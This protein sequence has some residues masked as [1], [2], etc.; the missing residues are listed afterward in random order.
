MSTE[1]NLEAVRQVIEQAFNQGNYAVLRTHFRPDFAEHQFGLHATIEGMQEDIQ[2]LRR[3]FPDLHLT[4]EDMAADG[5][6][7][8]VRSTARGTN[9]VGFMGPPNDKPFEMAVFDL[10]RFQD[11][12]IVEHWGTPDR[13][14]LLFQLGLLPRK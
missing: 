3:D 9:R 7:V 8:W 2:N 14:A 4:I 11:G 5:D 13:F 12:Q 6:K 10:L 1:G